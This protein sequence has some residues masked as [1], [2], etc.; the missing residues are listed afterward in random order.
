M[1]C[2]L[3]HAGAGNHSKFN[4]EK[5]NELCYEACLHASDLMCFE[6]KNAVDAVETAV[7]YLEDCSLTNAGLGSN[8]TIN[9]FVECDA[10]I[11]TSSTHQFAGVGAVRNVRNPVKLARLLLQ[12]QID[13]PLGECGRV[14]PC[15]LVG[16]GVRAWAATKGHFIDTCDLTTRA[17]QLSWEKYRSWLHDD[18]KT[19]GNASITDCMPGCSY[20][21]EEKKSSFDTVG[22][23]CVDLEGNIASAA[24]SGGIAIKY[25]GRIGQACTYGCGCWA[26][27]LSLYSRIGTVTS[28]TG[29]Q[30]V[31][32]QLAQRCAERFS[33]SSISVPE[34]VKSSL[35]DG[36][37]NS[38]Y[39]SLDREKWAGIAG[40]YYNF[41]C[42]NRPVVDIF[43]A[44]STTSMSVGHYVP[45]VMRE[46]AAR[47]TRKQT[48][49]PIYLE[50]SSYC[51]Q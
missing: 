39:L 37:L 10:G 42:T 26:E 32:T 12:T 44:H 9:G 35:I 15:L 45:S 6:N 4:E 20:S 11:M 14:Q 5:Y 1:A 13:Q 36:F 24:S 30:L 19:N 33:G 46:P 8:L 43:V 27:E 41:E 47:I 21:S 51:L 34:V 23:V 2:V 3:V 17:S 40:V 31:K 22:A 38:K 29:E 7:A 48:D 18:D 16:D 25:E 50:V 28:G 49:E